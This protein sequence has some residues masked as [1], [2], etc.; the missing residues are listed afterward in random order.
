M[1][2]HNQPLSPADARPTPFEMS[3]LDAED[4]ERFQSSV[5]EVD[6]KKLHALWFKSQTFRGHWYEPDSTILSGQTATR[7][8]ASMLFSC[9]AHFGF[10][11]DEAGHLMRA[12]ISLHSELECRSRL[13]EEK[14]LDAKVKEAARWKETQHSA[15]SSST[16]KASEAS[17]FEGLAKLMVISQF[18]YDPVTKKCCV[19]GLMR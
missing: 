7:S 19:E 6:R 5:P 18:T 4:F 8:E 9:F 12:W 14:I 16:A 17:A 1:K 11:R 15:T 13:L 10:T 2:N 3:T